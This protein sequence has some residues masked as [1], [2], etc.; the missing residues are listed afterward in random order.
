MRLVVTIFVGTVHNQVSGSNKEGSLGGLDMKSLL[1]MVGA[2]LRG[3]VALALVTQMPSSSGEYFLEAVYF[4]T[5]WSNV[6]FGGLTVPLVTFLGIPN[7]IDGSLDLAEFQFTEEEA[8]YL[9]AID[10]TFARI[11]NALLVHAGQQQTFSTSDRG[12]HASLWEYKVKQAKNRGEAKLT[13]KVS[14]MPKVKKA[15]RA[16]DK[17]KADKMPGK[18]ENARAMVIKDLE[19]ALKYE[20]E[21]AARYILDSSVW[22]MSQG[23]SERSQQAERFD[24]DNPVFEDGSTDSRADETNDS[25][26]DD[27]TT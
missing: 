4:V 11:E 13:D 15:Q 3:P 9:D 25:D 12:R 24:T 22:D 27:G 23:V 18:S 19:H 5:F 7:E 2:G 17:A 8:N 26:I 14:K 20:E 10:K 16:L 1:L 21:V 6:V